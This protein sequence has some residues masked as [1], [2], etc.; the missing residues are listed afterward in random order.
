VSPDVSV[1]IPLFNR[2][3][4][5]PFTLESLCAERHPG[6][7]LEVIV[8]DDG[9]TD[10]GDK[11]A[12]QALPGTQLLRTPRTGAPKARNAGLATARASAIF[13]LDS[14][15]LVEPGFFLP[16]LTALAQHPAADAAYGPFEFFEGDG[17]FSEGLVRRRHA[18]YPVEPHIERDAH[19]LRLLRGW[20][21]PP[22]AILW[23]TSAV[24]RLGGYDEALRINQDVDL[25]FRA[26][27]TGAGI[28]GSVGPRALYRDHAGPGRQGV[29]GGDIR[30]AGDLLMLRRRFIADL[31]RA[32]LFG[33]AAR[34]AL[35]SYCFDEW[36]QLRD[37]MPAIAEDFY[38][39]SRSLHPHMRLP[40]RWPLR[41]LSATVGARRAVVLADAARR[42][43]SRLARRT[44][45][46]VPKPTL[47]A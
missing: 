28:V 39:L 47:H 5:I 33:I 11:I 15:D 8:I 43:T 45:S 22:P 37:T 46:P 44:L 16:R 2:A 24:R 36:C 26:L 14:D 4:L 34:Q 25:L 27:V 9:S 17:A 21:V 42:A 7:R 38:R 29:V 41:L 40:G 1:V 12:A 10:S 30:K 18:P 20:Y 6:V 31:E 32:G 13:F 23:R 35:G 19:F 3:N